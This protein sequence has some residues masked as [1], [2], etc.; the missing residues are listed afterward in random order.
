MPT[1]PYC[2]SNSAQHA[3]CGRATTDSTGWVATEASSVAHATAPFEVDLDQHRR[4]TRGSLASNPMA[5][6]RASPRCRRASAATTPIG[7]I[8][9]T[10]LQ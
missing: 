9:S 4:Q 7:A 8:A 6:S 3:P 1:P 2:G 5:A 10:W